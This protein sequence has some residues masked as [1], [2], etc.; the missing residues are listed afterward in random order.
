MGLYLVILLI[1]SITAYRIIWFKCWW[2]CGLGLFVTLF[3]QR[4]FLA[5][6]VIVLSLIV[7]LTMPHPNKLYPVNGRSM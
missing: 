1:F 2:L 7:R 4:P 6:A 3:I 5:L